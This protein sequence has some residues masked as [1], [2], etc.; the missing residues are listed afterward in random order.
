MYRK[1]NANQRLVNVGHGIW[2][3]SLSFSSENPKDGCCGGNAVLK[4]L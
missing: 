1:Q 4:A 2:F 3:S